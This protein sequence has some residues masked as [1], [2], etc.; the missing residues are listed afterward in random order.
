M[1]VLLLMGLLLCLPQVERVVE[2]VFKSRLSSNCQASTITYF[3]SKGE[4]K[5]ER[6]II[7]RGRG[8]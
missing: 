6:D 8:R 3:C 5:Q 7:P 2:P 1:D 4:E